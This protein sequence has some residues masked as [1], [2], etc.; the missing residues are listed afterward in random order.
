MSPGFCHAPWMLTQASLEPH[1]QLPSPVRPAPSLNPQWSYVPI[2]SPQ[3]CF[4]QDKCLTVTDHPGLAC[5]N[6]ADSPVPDLWPVKAFGV[7][8]SLPRSSRSTPHGCSISNSSMR[9]AVAGMPTWPGQ[10][11]HWGQERAQPGRHERG[12][13]RGQPN[14]ALL[15]LVLMAGTFFI[16]AFFLRKFKNGPV[17]PRLGVWAGRPKGA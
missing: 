6:S 12:R 10:R 4:Y 1:S 14:T 17:L 2:C 7:L 3:P 15:S 8:C 9:Q 16:C 13:P 5:P 11:P